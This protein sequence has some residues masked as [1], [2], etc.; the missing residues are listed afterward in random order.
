VI[1]LYDT[2]RREK[3]PLRPLEEGRLGVYVCG[4]TVYDM[5]HVGHARCYVA[6]D[7]VVRH[8][9][10]SGYQVR[11]VRNITDVDDKII[12]RAAELGEDPLALSARMADEFHRDMQAL[13]NLVPDVEP[14]VSGHISDIVA[15]TERLVA[16]GHA[17]EVDG[18]V[19]FEVA[20]FEAYGAL[21][22]RNLEELRAGARVEVD[23]RKRSPLDFALWKAAKPGEPSW[24]SPW[25][26]G[27]PGWHIECSAMSSRYL[28]DSFDIHGGGMDLIFPHHEN[29]IAQSRALAGPESFARAWLH[30]GFI[31]VRTADNLEEKM[32][33]SLGNFFTIRQVCERYEPE[34]LRLFLLGTHYRSPIAFE[35][36][37]TGSGQ[38]RFVSL[39]EAERRLAYS[40]GT[41]ARLEAALYEVGAM[42]NVVPLAARRRRREKN[43]PHSESFTAA[44]R[45]VCR[46]R[47]AFRKAVRGFPS[48]R[49]SPLSTS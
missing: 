25:G 49:I 10:E 6:F 11:Y 1:R 27:R 15:M 23:E 32:S 34:S 41:L 24:Q 4:P 20:R 37:A 48:M 36:D 40:Y 13:G 42:A 17:Y 28:G 46:R 31:T 14:R 38:P 8:L 18:D 9:R 21:S 7:V 43:R 47:S 16:S 12:R 29:E 3:V 35:V 22:K 44:R 5:C 19:Y 26:R 39:E 45:S 30:N 2:A 33:K